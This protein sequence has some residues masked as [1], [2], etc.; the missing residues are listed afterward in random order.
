MSQGARSH[1]PCPSVVR[2]G[3][4]L[5]QGRVLGS[6]HYGTSS[7]SSPRPACHR[8]TYKS[9]WP[10]VTTF[11]LSDADLWSQRNSLSNSPCPLG[12]A[13]GRGLIY[14]PR[15]RN[16]SSCYE[17]QANLLYSN[18]WCRLRF[19]CQ[20]KCSAGRILQ[21]TFFKFQVA[22]DDD[23]NYHYCRRLNQSPGPK[24]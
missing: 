24:P 23:G 11:M 10:G 5:T 7:P 14:S 22:S 16:C 21:V 8:S 19:A 20:S 1:G 13:R 12:R 3:P 2:F 6:V 17:A 9:E 15:T 18:H 4:W